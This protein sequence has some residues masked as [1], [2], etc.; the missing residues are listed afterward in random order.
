M[1]K[2]VIALGLSLGLSS[3][4][5]AAPAKDAKAAAPDA[6]LVT[7]KG[8]V[9]DMACY[10]DHGAKGAEHAQCAQTC[11]KS[12]LP[13]GL[14]ADNGKTYLLIAEH[15][16]VN[17]MLADYGGKTVTLRGKEA[18]RDGFNLLENVELVK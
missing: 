5:F 12:G 10:L 14:K 3:F 6:G 11:I 1:K 7:V 17:Q 8:E 15:T 16:P 2:T 9:L 18:Q 4:A 13:V